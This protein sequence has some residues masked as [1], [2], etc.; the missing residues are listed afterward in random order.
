MSESTAVSLRGTRGTDR[1]SS[2]GITENTSRDNGKKA[3][4]RATAC[5]NL[6]KETGMRESGKT[7]SKTERDFMS[8]LEDQS[9]SAISK[10]S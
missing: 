10:I 8:T 5:G 1:D 2:N 4:N 3:R 7:A 9:T 6:Q